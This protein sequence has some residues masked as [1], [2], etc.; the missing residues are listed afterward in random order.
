MGISMCQT[1]KCRRLKHATKDYLT[2]FISDT[3]H[4]WWTDKGYHR[5]IV[6]AL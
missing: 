5:Y 3:L 1:G 4:I 2:I 6:K